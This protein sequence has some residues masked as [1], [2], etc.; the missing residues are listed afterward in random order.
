MSRRVCCLFLALIGAACGGGGGLDYSGTPG[1][2]VM[3]SFDGVVATI[4]LDGLPGGTKDFVVDTGAP[5]TI[6]DKDSFPTIPPGAHKQTFS[7]FG[8]TFPDY[9]IG[10]WNLF[11]D[12]PGTA[13]DGLL[14]GDLLRNF[15]FTLDYK[16][17]RAWLDDPWDPTLIPA[18]VSTMPEHDV[19]IDVAGGGAS[20]VPDTNDVLA[21]PPTRVL[22]RVKLE[23]QTTPIWALVDS[24]ATFVTIEEATLTAL[25][26]TPARPRLDGVVVATANGN[27]T[28]YA[29]RVSRA[30]LIDAHDETLPYA[31]DDL[32]VLVI[33]GT[34][35]F[36]GLS[37]EVGR[38]VKAFIGGTLLR[39]HLTTFDY[40]EKLLRLAPYTDESHI[41]PREFVSPGR[42]ELF[43]N[44]AGEWRFAHV[45]PGSNVE[46][47]GIVTG[48]VV[49]QIA[50][51][52]ITGQPASFVFALLDGIPLGQSVTLGVQRG[53]MV[54][55]FAVVVQDLLPSYPP[56]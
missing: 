47:A 33:P 7:A 32:P 51:M 9:P 18:D 25:G 39:R 34:D 31:N 20:Q 36:D 22:L 21:V 13:A 28:S 41:D 43:T 49:E 3:A 45:Y 14:G 12:P 37:L 35:L 44:A 48:D 16:G 53:G 56:T 17:G 15:A 19:K 6:F 1:T 23:G 54:Q 50:G 27:V 10:V 55:D 29:S 52:P 4:T 8:L 30:T 11:A 40:Q 46:A 24:G 26:N 42:L 5:I 2:P 38:P